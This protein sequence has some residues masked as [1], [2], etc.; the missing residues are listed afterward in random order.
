MLFLNELSDATVRDTL[1]GNTRH[2]LV[3]ILC[4]I[5]M[6]PNSLTKSNDIGVRLAEYNPSLRWHNI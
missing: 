2:C 1:L 5:A 4:F 3:T 6:L